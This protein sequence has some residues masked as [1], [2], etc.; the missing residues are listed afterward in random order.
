[1]MRQLRGRNLAH[2]GCL[3]GITLGLTLGIILAGVLAVVFNVAFSTDVLIWF[4]LTIV[5]GAIGWFVGDRLS[6][7]FPALEDEA[8]DELPS[9]PAPGRSDN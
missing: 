6:S 3:I 2:P 5:L 4:G 9:H 8:G 1:M 7:R